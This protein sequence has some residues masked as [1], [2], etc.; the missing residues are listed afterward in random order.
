LPRV[1]R[2]L[3]LEVSLSRYENPTLRQAQGRL[4]R[5]KNAPEM[6]RLTLNLTNDL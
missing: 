4:S 1:A 3:D 6:G 5:T 2:V